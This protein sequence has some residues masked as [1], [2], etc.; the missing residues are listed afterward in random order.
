MKIVDLSHTIEE[1]MTL[2]PG[3]KPPSIN[4]VYSIGT[5][6]FKESILSITS[7][8]GTHIDVPAHLLKDGKA[9]DSFPVDSFIGL[10]IRIDCRNVQKISKS[11]IVEEVSKFPSAEFILF[12]TGWDLYWRSE[13]YFHDFPI[14]EH[15]AVEYIV[16]L[17]IK[18]VGID[19]ISFDPVADD[20]LY[21][22]HSFMGKELILAENLCNMGSL[23]ENQ[24]LFCCL[25]LKIKGLDGCPV[26]A[27]GLIN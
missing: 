11:L 15:N 6:G 2:Y 19:A 7:H 23:P 9:L 27:F 1:N 10:G 14:L 3:T 13:K 16:S 4:E 22:H 5:D 24:F 12:H 20:K 25:P 8:T 21:N 18:G 17:Q 26:R